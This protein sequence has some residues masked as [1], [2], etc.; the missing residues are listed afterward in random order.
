MFM[1]IEQYILERLVVRT[2]MCV[3]N[4]SCLF[5]FERARRVRLSLSQ[6]K[7]CTNGDVSM[8]C[9]ITENVLYPVMLFHCL[10]ILKVPAKLEGIIFEAATTPTHKPRALECINPLLPCT[11]YV[12]VV[13]PVGYGAP[14]SDCL[15]FVGILFGV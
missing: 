6:V 2:A 7:I 13:V 11:I 8:K 15:G 12:E 3:K 5:R 14:N 4:A 1:E 9:Y 10:H